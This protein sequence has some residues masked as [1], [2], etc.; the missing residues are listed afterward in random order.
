MYTNNFQKR[1]KE[2][3]ATCWGR[4]I[5]Q[6]SRTRLCRR[7]EIGSDTKN[8]GGGVKEMSYWLIWTVVVK[9]RTGQT[10][11]YCSISHVH[12]KGG[13]RRENAVKSNWGI[14]ESGHR[15]KIVVL[16]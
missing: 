12:P 13:V 6:K 5:I 4:V 8:T 16:K 7:N 11:L 3:E 14:R 9:G 10:A 2:P 1:G 15:Y